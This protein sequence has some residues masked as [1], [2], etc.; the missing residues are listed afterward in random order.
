MEKNYNIKQA[1]DLLGIKIRTVR[2]WIRDNK[3]HGIKYPASPRWFIPESEIKRVRGDK[4]AD[5]N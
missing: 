2:Q 5:E 3:I 1:S 4:I